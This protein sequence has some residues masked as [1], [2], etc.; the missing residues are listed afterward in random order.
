MPG[1][2]GCISKDSCAEND[3]DISSMSSQLLHN[4]YHHEQ[5]VHTAP[6]TSIAV[7]NPGICSALCATTYCSDRK[8]SLAYYGE[9]YGGRFSQLGDGEAIAQHLLDMYFSQGESFV[10]GLNGSFLIFIENLK[11]N[12]SL[13][14]N[15]HYAS[16]PLFFSIKGERIF[17]SPEVKAIYGLPFISS[18]V[19]KSAVISFL[20]NG[21]VLNDQTYFSNIKALLPGSI[22]RIE[23]NATSIESYHSHRFEVEEDRGEDYYIDRLSTLLRQAVA[24][25]FTDVNNTIIPISGGYDSRGILGCIRE[26]TE[27]KIK[28]VSWGTD[29]VTVGSDAYIGRMIA[30]K[31]NC[32]HFFL[33][34]RPGQLISSFE[35]MQYV[36]DNLTD[37]PAIHSQELMIMKR[38]RSELGGLFMMR[39]DECFGFGG[40]A[41]NDDE[42]LGRVAINKLRRLSSLKGLLN[43]EELD[44]YIM[45]YDAVVDDIVSK[46]PESDFLDRKDYYYFNQ[47]LF[48]YLNRSSYY[49]MGVLELQNPWLD[50]RILDFIATVPRKYR[51]DKQLYK[52]TLETMFPD[53]YSIPFASSSSLESWSDIFQRDVNLQ[54]YL[55]HH[56]LEDSNEFYGFLNINNLNSKLDMMFSDRIEQTPSVSFASKMKALLRRFPL[57]YR[58]IKSTAVKYMPSNDVTDE[59]LILRLL[60]TKTWFD[61]LKK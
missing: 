58:L 18:E 20:V 53:L 2:V 1:I 25:R 11:D 8:I 56:L 46:C 38:I 28:T 17:I 33:E 59:T 44:S 16:R 52:K 10:D 23:K 3:F 60:L 9:F 21:H 43:P 39:G 41:N 51:L 61:K 48:N 55:R 14:F 37:D 12:I 5:H 34:R 32:Q 57:I 30:E 15:D 6:G 31:L 50:K 22:F 24:D 40:E 42:A 54:K 29:E 4:E 49:K 7:I 36:T 35:E 45:S 19:D 47:R 27:E 26:L 13:I